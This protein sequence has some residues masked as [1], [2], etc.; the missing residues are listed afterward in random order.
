MS[1]SPVGAQVLPPSGE[2]HSAPS[3]AALPFG[4]LRWKAYHLR[5]SGV[6]PG[7]SRKGNCMKREPG[8]VSLALSPEPGMSSSCWTRVKLLPPSVER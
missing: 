3:S 6:P 5:V 7:T 8:I 1:A 2:L 4:T